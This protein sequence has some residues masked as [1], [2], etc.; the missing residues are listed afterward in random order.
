MHAR[1]TAEEGRRLWFLDGACN[2]AEQITALILKLMPQ[3]CK[4]FMSCLHQHHARLA[5][6][7]YPDARS[8]GHLLALAPTALLKSRQ[9]SLEYDCRTDIRTYQQIFL[10]ARQEMSR[11]AVITHTVD[12]AG[13]Q[14]GLK[15]CHSK[16]L[17]KSTGAWL[18]KQYLCGSN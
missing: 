18:T 3:N 4:A 1:Y 12:Q 15:I 14:L 2:F 17:F 8:L 6:L 9:H 10:I 13:I 16:I 11:Y 7:S 5:L